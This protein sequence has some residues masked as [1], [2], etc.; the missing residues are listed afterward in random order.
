MLPHRNGRRFP[1]GIDGIYAITRYPLRLCSLVVMQ[2]LSMS[3]DVVYRI[4]AADRLCHV[5]QAWEAFARDNSG[6]DF[7]AERVLGHSLWSYV[8]DLTLAQ[9]YRQIIADARHGRDVRLRFRCDAP[10]ERRLL[11]MTVRGT[12]SGV[13]QFSTHEIGVVARPPEMLFDA[14]TPRAGM[15]VRVCSWC[16]RVWAGNRWLEVEQ[17]VERMH[18]MLSSVLPPLAHAACKPCLDIIMREVAGLAGDRPLY[19]R[20]ALLFSVGD[21]ADAMLN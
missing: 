4:D 18:L 16:N 6:G 10:R 5:N 21:D 14:S 12:G 11:E 19:R 15:P 13:V 17:A 3:V 2:V 8:R 9:V 20:D 1:A 7:G